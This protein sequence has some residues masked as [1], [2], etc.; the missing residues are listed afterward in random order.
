MWTAKHCSMLSSSGQTGCSFFAVYAEVP[1][2][3]TNPISLL[4]VRRTFLNFVPRTLTCKNW[5]W[6][7][8][9]FP[10]ENYTNSR[11]TYLRDLRLWDWTQKP[12]AFSNRRIP[13]AEAIL[14][15]KYMFVY[16]YRV[17]TVLYRRVQFINWDPVGQ[18][19]NALRSQLHN[20]FLSKHVQ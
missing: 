14:Q 11:D 5:N 18:K 12:S 2:L 3:Q 17:L 7:L 20:D 19:R 6:S 10:I 13:H 15:G 1:T 9:G 16:L 8:K 4:Y